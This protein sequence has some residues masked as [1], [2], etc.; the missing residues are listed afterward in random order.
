MFQMVLFF[1]FGLIFLLGPLLLEDDAFPWISAG[2]SSNRHSPALNGWFS[3]LNFAKMRELQ[4]E[5]YD[6]SA[7]F[8]I[9][10]AIAAIIRWDDRPPFFEVSF[11]KSL[12]ALQYVGAALNSVV[13]M[14]SARRYKPRSSSSL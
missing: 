14:I 2:S 11:M 5:F 1:K 9:P 10:I 4:W 6:I 3:D 12:L 8:S 13:L 7:L